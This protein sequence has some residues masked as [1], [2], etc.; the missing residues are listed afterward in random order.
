MDQRPENTPLVEFHFFGHTRVF[1]NGVNQTPP[2]KLRCLLAILV[3]ANRGLVLADSTS[4]PQEFQIN[5]DNRVS[6]SCLDGLLFP[7]LDRWEAAEQR[8][9]LVLK[10]RRRFSAVRVP[11]AIRGSHIFRLFNQPLPE[12]VDVF[13]FED[14]YNRK[15]YSLAIDRYPAPLLLDLDEMQQRDIVTDDQLTRILAQCGTRRLY[16]EMFEE[17]VQAYA[18]TSLDSPFLIERRLTEAIRIYPD[19]REFQELRARIVRR[20][21]TEPRTSQAIVSSDPTAQSGDPS[22]QPLPS[23]PKPPLRYVAHT[24]S[25]LQSRNLIGRKDELEALDDWQEDPNGPSVFCVEAMGGAGKSALTWSWF[26]DRTPEFISRNYAGA[27][28]W[29]FY[30]RDAG[31][32]SFIAHALAYI[33]GTSL[34]KVVE[35]SLADQEY[36]LLSSL[37]ARPYLIVLDG[38]ERLLLAYTRAES[39]RMLDESI[40]AHSLDVLG[41]AD[42]RNESQEPRFLA[43][44]SQRKAA[45]P[46]VGSFLRRLSKI[47]K[48]RILVTTRLAFTDL[49]TTT[50]EPMVGYRIWKLPPLQPLDALQLW[51]SLGA[52]GEDHN[53]LRQLDK[54]QY[55]P[56]LV[57]ALAGEVARWLPSPGNLEHWLDAH[58]GF[59]FSTLPAHQIKSHVLW[60]AM[61]GLPECARWV[62]N[63]ISAF[64]MPVKYA[65]LAAIATTV[66]GVAG[67]EDDV[68]QSAIELE[69]R[70]LVGRN[71]ITRCYDLHPLVRAVAWAHC[72]QGERHAIF[73][74][75]RIHLDT[76]DLNALSN[77]WPKVRRVE[78][79]TNQI[80]LYNALIGEGE[81]DQAFEC[82]Q[83]YLVLPL[84]YRLK[85]YLLQV[86]LL[87]QMLTD[88]TSPTFGL[89]KASYAQAAKTDLAEAL[90]HSGQPA[91]V[92][93][94]YKEGEQPSIYYRALLAC[95][96]LAEAEVV[97][98]N[99]CNEFISQG[100]D[101]LVAALH[102]SYLGYTLALQGQDADQVM[103]QSLGLREQEM[104]RAET[105]DSGYTVL[106]N[107]AQSKMLKS[108]YAEAR[109]SAAA[110]ISH[111]KWCNGQFNIPDVTD[112]YDRDISGDYAMAVCI[113]GKAFASE[114]KWQLAEERLRYAL[115]EARAGSKI[116]DELNVLIAY[117]Q[118][119]FQVGQLDRA[120]EFLD[121]AWEPIYRGSY[122]LLHADALEIK[123][124]IAFQEG[125]NEAAIETVKA[126]CELAYCDGPSHSY[127]SR[128]RSLSHF[129]RELEQ[130]EPIAGH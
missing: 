49:E 108:S 10:L 91:R 16:Q 118:L 9:Q 2:G 8:R 60:Y 117:A 3:L 11:N 67:S 104:E 102:L 61:R 75:I 21:M 106:L 48:S 125:D 109:D 88:E 83:Q 94:L 85:A 44:R 73:A 127:S 38:A 120:R 20:V 22:D 95:G 41:G 13:D 130:E 19:N 80:E 40:D 29:S 18:E 47:G 51:R 31:Y 26:T 66:P 126:A 17:A 93:T 113:E 45:D 56:L 62:L 121:D 72:A 105:D 97:L 42:N 81:F 5:E 25:L 12:Y 92:S 39:A 122:R 96:R 43:D 128:V 68:I 33:S 24:Y 107:I 36:S 63:I 123:A 6:T 101:K 50:G 86:R 70:G 114:G 77:F 27:M 71:T 112:D 111:L 15:E 30:E 79:I 129:L 35:M 119:S 7:E 98:R 115:R 90:L 58:P 76:P 69:E 82:Y 59:D 116:E 46:Y 32:E 99:V 52:G 78:D 87:E 34:D 89:T 1:V 28:W 37:T 54:L 57:Q 65:D 103:R 124:R 23:V 110:A 55:H 74:A 84:T 64:R 53:V 14:A 100:R 4:K